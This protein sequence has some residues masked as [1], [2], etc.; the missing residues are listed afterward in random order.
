MSSPIEVE[1]VAKSQATVPVESGVKGQ[2]I[3]SSDEVRDMIDVPVEEPSVEPS[4]DG[5]KRK[6]KTYEVWQYFVEVEVKEKGK[7]VKKLGCIH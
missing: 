5:Q 1:S 7:T 4:V 3:E 6:S 2:I